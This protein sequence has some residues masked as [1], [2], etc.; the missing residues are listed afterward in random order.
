MLPFPASDVVRVLV[1]GPL[2]L[3][4]PGYVA[5]LAVLPRAGHLARAV[6]GFV[7]TL[8]V[9]GL[10]T[11]GLHAWA[12]V[13]YDARLV[14]GVWAAWCALALAAAWLARRAWA[15]LPRPRLA[16]AHAGLAAALALQ[17][18]WIAWPHGAGGWLPLHVDEWWPLA[19]SQAIAAQGTTAFV[20]PQLG[21]LPIVQN[22]E[23]GFHLVAVDLQ[24]LTGASWVGLFVL[25]PFVVG[26][27][28]VAASFACAQREAYGVEAALV[29]A[30]LPTSVRVLGPQLFVPL[31][32]GLL[33][34]P[35]GFLLF[36][37]GAPRRALPVLVLLVVELVFVHPQ[38]AL[39][40]GIL[41]GT[42]AL[43][44]AKRGWAR[45]LVLL[46]I[47]LLPTL[48]VYTV[49]RERAPSGDDLLDATSSLPVPEFLG[50]FGVVAA[51][52]FLGGA[53]ATFL[54]PSAERLA[55]VATS[56]A[57]LVLIAL[58]LVVHVGQQNLYDRA[59]M[60][61]MLTM[62][63]TAA[64]GL[65]ALRS[66]WPSRRRVAQAAALALVVALVA[67]AGLGQAARQKE[68]YRVVSDEDLATFAW[69]RDHV[70]AN[71]TRTLLDPWQGTAYAA[72]TGHVVF[73]AKPFSI[74]QPLYN[75]S[76][77]SNKSSPYYGQNNANLA[78]QLL[79]KNAT[80]EKTLQKLGINVVVTPSSVKNANFTEAHPH[81]WVRNNV[82]LT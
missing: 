53:M 60:H 5:L 69:V 51:L 74:G 65:H 41:V 43:L 15:P 4:L 57:H 46:V 48:L 6:V 29:V 61:G 63:M 35:A 12:G 39:A 72:L 11:W 81:V 54:R 7:L 32:T 16:W 44:T 67:T 56:F 82:T 38:S 77:L 55:W 62:S 14:W 20:D 70:P 30:L 26:A 24:M 22:P 8:S 23:V 3:V 19:A 27:F 66:S 1:L 52:L 42:Y 13:R 2:L 10:A 28:L 33:F 58:F 75:Q 68:Y 59:W 71:G 17:A 50:L 78:L 9:L 31:A 18:A 37:S 21:I 40:L 25:A 49:Y 80:D 76:A 34:I 79:A 73:A 45:A 47:A 36:T 64:F